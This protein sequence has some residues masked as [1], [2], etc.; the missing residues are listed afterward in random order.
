[1]AYNGMMGGG[2]MIDDDDKDEA[3]IYGPILFSINK[4]D[5]I[6]DL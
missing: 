2:T 5:F 4:H 1:M 6:I 3:G